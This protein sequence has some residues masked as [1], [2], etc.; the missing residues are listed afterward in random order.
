VPG[1][2]WPFASQSLRLTEGRNNSFVGRD[3]ASDLFATY[4]LG[5]ADRGG[6]TLEVAR[7]VS[8]FEALPV[9]G[10]GCA[11]PGTAAANLFLRQLDERA[12]SPRPEVNAFRSGGIAAG[13]DCQV[14]SSAGWVS[15]FNV[16]YAEDQS[17]VIRSSDRRLWPA[18]QVRA[19]RRFLPHPD[20]KWLRMAFYFRTLNDAEMPGGINSLWVH[21]T[22][23]GSNSSARASFF[24]FDP[25]GPVSAEDVTGICADFTGQG[26]AR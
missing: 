6:V 9:L 12:A 23:D 24:G 16:E 22:P 14:V 2:S 15:R 3:E 26:A 10:G 1:Q 4:H 20:P 21:A 19:E 13:R 8:G 5:F 18:P 17:V 25:E 11:E 7:G